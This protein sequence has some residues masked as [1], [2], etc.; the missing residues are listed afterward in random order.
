LTQLWISI[1]WLCPFQDGIWLREGERV[2][3]DPLGQISC[4]VGQDKQGGYNIEESWGRA[5]PILGTRPEWTYSQGTARDSRWSMYKMYIGIMLQFIWKKKIGISWV[6]CVMHYLCLIIYCS[7]ACMIHSS[8]LIVYFLCRLK[9][10]NDSHEFILEF[11]TVANSNKSI[12]IYF[13]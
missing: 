6:T 9:I 12:Y 4:W 1:R 3:Y 5:Q 11:G 7:A 8:C 13:L 2:K 10:N